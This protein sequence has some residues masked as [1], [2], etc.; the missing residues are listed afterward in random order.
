MVLPR[1]L[2]AFSFLGGL[3]TTAWQQVLA[4]GPSARSNNFVLIDAEDASLCTTTG[5]VETHIYPRTVGRKMV[6]LHPGARLSTVTESTNVSII[7]P[8]LFDTPGPRYG[9]FLTAKLRVRVDAQP[10]QELA[11]ATARRE[12]IIA[13][14]LP[15]GKHSIE[16]EPVDGIAI[17][18]AFRVSDSPFAGFT[19]TLVAGDYSELFTDARIDVFQNDQKIRTE[20]VG[21]PRLGMFELYGLPAGNYRLQISAAGWGDVSLDECS[22]AGPGHRPDLGLIALARDPR[23]G[24]EDGQDRPGAHF[25]RSVCVSPGGSFRTLVNLPSPTIK[26]AL[27]HSRFK[28]LDLVASDVKKLPLGRWNNVGEATFAI[29]ENAPSDM[30][31][32]VLEFDTPRG[33]FR[34]VSGQAVCVRPQLPPAFHVAGCGHMNTWGQQT[35][36]YLKRVA[37]VAQLAGARTLLIANEVNPAYISGALAELRI[38]YVVTRGNHTVGRWDEFYGPSSRPHDD[39][40]MRIVDFGRWPYEPW[41]EVEALFRSRPEATNRVV[42]C[43]EGFAPL[44]LI[45]E[46]QLDLLFDAH[47]DNLHADRDSFPPRTFHMRAPNQE[48]LRW[49]PM[50]HDGLAKEVKTNIDV[51]VLAIPRTG[52]SPLRTEFEFAADGTADRQSVTVTNEYPIEFPHAAVRLVLRR[53]K[54]SVTGGAVSQQFDSDD[55]RFAVIDVVVRIPAKSAVP[56]RAVPDERTGRS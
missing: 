6:L 33:A 11:P 24:G 50:T 29:P 26:R 37:E 32:L 54:Y 12:T 36:E 35:A 9:K 19:G 17:V 18:D 31:D 39:G 44:S 43:Y 23:C 14:K 49:I 10:W 55:G 51:P 21:S 56:I 5:R 15:A 45:R 47:S 34:Q 48:S 7:L 52:R 22:I 42:V 16:V 8:T 40:P 13:E 38:P 2:V 28:S 30:Y 46:Q 1:L 25:G 3:L 41:T 27:L 4:A 20:Y 53:G